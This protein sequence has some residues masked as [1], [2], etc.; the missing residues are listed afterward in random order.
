MREATTV[1]TPEAAAALG[2]PP[3]LTAIGDPSLLREPLVAVL[4]SKRCPGNLV[5]QA[6]DLA[7]ALRDSGVPTIGGF[8][9][10]V[11]RECLDFLLRGHQPV[12]ICPARGITGMRLPADWRAAVEQERLLVVSP[13]PGTIRRPTAGTSEQRNRLVV[14]LAS[15]V[16][17]IHAN[18]G[19]RTEALVH[20]AGDLGKPTYALA[21]PANAHLPA[22]GV[23]ASDLQRL[24]A[25]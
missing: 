1:S 6:Y 9:T 12:V 4:C 5:L 8:H 16:L 7:V 14:A 21:D 3:M 2:F 24:T 19:G 13:F 18:P 22:V 25:V 20:H 11:E 23:S 10:P 17:V 15:K